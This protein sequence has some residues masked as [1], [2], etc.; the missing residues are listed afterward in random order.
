MIFK[1]GDT[2]IVGKSRDIMKDDR[3]PWKVFSN[4][5]DAQNALIVGTDTASLSEEPTS[6][7][8]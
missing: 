6:E 5:H 2:V 1:P 8:Q 7:N 4:P 3:G